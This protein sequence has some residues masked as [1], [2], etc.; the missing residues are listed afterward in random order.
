[1]PCLN[2]AATIAEC[3]ESAKTYIERVDIEAEILIAD[4]GSTDGSKEIALQHGARVVECAQKGYGA[5]L[6]TGIYSAHGKF[7]IFGDAD[8][9][10]DFQ[11]LDSFV[12]ELRLGADL[13]VG[14]RF[15]GGIAKGAMPFLHQYLGNPV[16]SW[17]G[18]RLFTPELSDFHCGL[19]GFKT[20]EIRR[21]GLR[22]SGME[23]ASEMIAKAGL[24][25]L[26]IKEVPTT[27]VKDKRGR[28]A[29][30]KTWRDGWRHLK[31][32]LMFAPEPVLL[33]PG[34]LLLVIGVTSNIVLAFGELQIFP[35]FSLHTSTLL[36]SCLCVIVGSQLLTFFSM[37]QNIRNKMFAGY[38][39]PRQNIF[40]GT[41]FE[42][43][44]LAGLG[45][46]LLGILLIGWAIYLWSDSNFGDLDIHITSRFTL[47]GA[48]LIA[49]SVQLFGAIFTNAAFDYGLTKSVQLDEP[50][51]LL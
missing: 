34:A 11:R 10:Y 6:L 16:L 44:L 2:E 36:M 33:W 15:A 29:H 9:S 46:L 42:I 39:E 20:E 23:F 50:D 26:C 32:L 43:A 8:C 18:K 4:N 51:P 30:L 7:I 27:L 49:V 22:C 31:F 25:G 45:T 35:G 14:N 1:M 13:V 47:S 38:W 28:P 37:L 40:R 48:T 19:R 3:I 21:L 24:A 41:N 12:E 17:I 5:A